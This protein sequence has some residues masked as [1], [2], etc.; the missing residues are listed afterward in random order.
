MQKQT[1]K[2]SPLKRL[3]DSVNKSSQNYFRAEWMK[4]NRKTRGAF[5]KRLESPFTYTDDLAL[6]QHIFSVQALYEIVMECYHFPDVEKY[7]RLEKIETII[8]Q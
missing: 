6:F 8:A 5:Y 7:N 1:T 3:Y 2:T 4:R